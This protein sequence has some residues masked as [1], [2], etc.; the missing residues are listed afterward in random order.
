MYELS[1]QH[2]ALN[3][4]GAVVLPETWW[5]GESNPN[6]NKYLFPW[7]LNH[8][9]V[10]FVVPDYFQVPDC[11]PVQGANGLW[12]ADK[13]GLSNG[14]K[15]FP[16]GS[17]RKETACNAEDLDSIPELGRT[18]GEGMATHSSILAW[19]IPW[20]E[21][22]C[23]LYSMGSQRVRQLSDFTSMA[24]NMSTLGSGSPCDSA[25]L[26]LIYESIVQVLEWLGREADWHPRNRSLCSPGYGASPPFWRF[27]RW[28]NT[29]IN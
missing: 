25:G 22:S 18:T 26:N 5:A 15:G 12:L 10:W 19:R 20:T 21:A 3:K 14:N 27:S 1:Q 2:K 24:I 11:P 29:F 8:Y 17:D 28:I 16:G 9:Y 13:S 7:G 6:Q 4:F 23:G